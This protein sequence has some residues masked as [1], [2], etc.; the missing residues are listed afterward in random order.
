MYL[1]CSSL[2]SIG[3]KLS[4]AKHNLTLAVGGSWAL[5]GLPTVNQTTSLFGLVRNG[6]RNQ[7]RGLLPLG[8]A[9]AGLGQA[10]RPGQHIRATKH[11]LKDHY[12]HDW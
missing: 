1:H 5:V 9:L 8:Q 10:S 7:T 4:H 6:T 3:L 12:G 11:A 2:L